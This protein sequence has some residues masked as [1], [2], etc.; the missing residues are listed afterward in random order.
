MARVVQQRTTPPYL[1]IVMVFLFLIAST[2]AVL[3]YLHADKMGKQ[4]AKMTETTRQLADSK[5]LGDDQVRQ[6]MTWYRE[7]PAGDQ[8]GKTV[9]KRM[10]ETTDL[11]TQ[12]MTGTATSPQ[13]AIAQSES[14]FST[15]GSRTGLVNEVT[16]LHT[17]LEQ[18]KADMAS[19]D[20]LIAQ[21]DAELA[22][23]QTLLDN[24]TADLEGKV[25]ALNQQVAELDG[26]LTQA[27]D[28]Y[29]TDLA[30][31]R[32][33]W[34]RQRAEMDRNIASK[35]QVTQEL[36]LRT[37]DLDGQVKKLQKRLQVATRPED[38]PIKVAQRS[39]GRIL[40]ILPEEGICYINLGVR[41]RIAPGLSFTVY[42][43]TGIPEEGTGKATIVVTNVGATTS[44]C[45]IQKE[46]MSDPIVRGDIVANLAF[47]PTQTY[48]FVVEGVFD[49]YGTGRA[50][51]EGTEEVKALIKRFGG[52]LGEAV[53]VDTDFIVLGS[54]PAR[55]PKPPDTAPLQVQQAYRDNLAVFQ[56]YAQIR[57]KA[58]NL[59]IPI[60]NTSR[61]LAFVGY[62]P[63]RAGG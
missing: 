38:K 40:E 59:N 46:E 1:L 15:I 8:A 27:R 5:D 9:V 37:Q 21:K 49:L 52:Q 10:K 13:A 35:T 34:D 54:E 16:S 23:K 14:A 33:E 39:D 17:K 61:F 18:A 53:S 24:V 26:K 31:A 2:V 47:D 55:I 36:E 3:M 48:T 32:G 25:T 62:V 43:P 19:K 28:Q 29:Q 51:A 63:T 4:T 44:E 30:A 7:P 57:E 56:R 11:L 22:Q 50:N 58:E 45:R 12:L 6:M 60:L 42:P 41:D 20:Q